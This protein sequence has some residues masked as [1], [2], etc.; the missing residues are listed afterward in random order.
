VHLKAVELSLWQT[1][2]SVIK[3]SSLKSTNVKKKKVV[4]NIVLEKPTEKKQTKDTQ[5]SV[6]Y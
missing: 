4:A 6:C 5:N 2:N 1:A 3:L